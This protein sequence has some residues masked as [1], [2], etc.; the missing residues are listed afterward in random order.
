MD[1]R[2]RLQYQNRAPRKSRWADGFLI[3]DDARNIGAGAAYGLVMALLT[4]AFI[5]PH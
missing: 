1:F 5:Y 4:A 2:R 3:G